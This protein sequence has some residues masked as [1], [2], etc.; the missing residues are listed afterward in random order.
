MP[1]I[2]RD[3]TRL[4]AAH[5]YVYYRLGVPL[6]VPGHLAAFDAA[7]IKE[8]RAGTALLLE[9]VIWQYDGFPDAAHLRAWGYA[10]V[11]SWGG[12]GSA[13]IRRFGLQSIRRR[14]ADHLRALLGDAATVEVWV[15]R[16]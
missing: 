8:A 11:R 9:N 2:D 12:P 16:R 13:S 4:I 7:A 3:P 6:T 10:P 1:E 5:P 14:P 15:K